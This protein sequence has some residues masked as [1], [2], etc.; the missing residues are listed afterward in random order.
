MIEMLINLI[1]LCIVGGLIYYLITLLPLPDP[2]KLIV[3]CAVVLIMILVL[4]SMF[5]G[6]GIG[7]GGMIR[8]QYR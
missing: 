3:T 1:V 6:G 5:W 2:F 8:L 4:V 7:S